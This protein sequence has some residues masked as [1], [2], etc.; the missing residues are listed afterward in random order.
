MENIINLIKNNR[1]GILFL[2]NLNITD[3]MLNELEIIKEFDGYAI[4]LANNKLTTLPDWFSELKIENLNV[5]YNNISEIPDSIMN[6][7][8]LK[9][10]EIPNTNITELSNELLIKLSDIDI[11][12]C[13]INELPSI[14]FDL[15]TDNLLHIHIDPSMEH[16]VKYRL[17]SN[18]TIYLSSNISFFEKYTQE[19]QPNQDKLYPVKYKSARSVIVN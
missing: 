6:I 7:S 17:S 19:N 10:L 5:G 8:K 1:R 12:Q 18:T 13:P 3:E 15:Y 11:C 2:N 4:E 9:I 14:V 16:L